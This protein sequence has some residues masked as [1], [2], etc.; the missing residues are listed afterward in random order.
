MNRRLLGLS[1]AV[2][3]LLGACGK[4][5]EITDEDDA[6]PAPSQT[7]SQ[8]NAGLEVLDN[9]AEE[10]GMNGDGGTMIGAERQEQ[11]ADWVQ[12]T[13]ARGGDVSGIRLVDIHQSSLYRFDNDS[14]NPSKST[15]NDMCALTWPPVTVQEGGRVYLEGVNAQRIG[16]IRRDDGTVQIT[17]GGWPLY[18]FS[19]DSQP[20]ELNGQGRDGV[21]FAVS[22]EGQK[23]E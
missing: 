2:L 23:V 15:C 19:G 10:N 14:A 21:W 6:T 12:L 5:I 16:A 3:L 13:A 9:S 1:L 17:A 4:S 11:P 18:R 20:G 22:P 7:T 8:G